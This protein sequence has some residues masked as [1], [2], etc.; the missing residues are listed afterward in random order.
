MTVDSGTS[1]QEHETA[2]L[3]SLTKVVSPS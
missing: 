1:L 2:A 3:I